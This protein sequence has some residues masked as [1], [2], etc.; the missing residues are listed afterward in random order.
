MHPKDTADRTALLHGE[1]G[2]GYCNI[3]RCCEELCKEYGVD[4]VL[5][6]DSAERIRSDGFQ[7]RQLGTVPV[8]GK[9][10]PLTVS[11]LT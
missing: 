8:R 11:M 6:S 5:S 7:L 3:T 10:Q 9:A 1:A 2:V 4:S